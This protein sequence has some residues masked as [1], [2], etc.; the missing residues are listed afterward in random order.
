LHC[1]RSLRS[2]LLPVN[3]ANTAMWQALAQQLRLSLDPRCTARV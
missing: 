2:A 3:D 1:D